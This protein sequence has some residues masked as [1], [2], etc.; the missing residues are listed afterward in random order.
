M[1]KLLL[2]VTGIAL[3]LLLLAVAGG[4]ALASGEE[5]VASDVVEV[6]VSND[7][8]TVS[9]ELDVVVNEAQDEITVEVIEPPAA[10]DA[11]DVVLSDDDPGDEHP[12]DKHD[13]E[14]HAEGG[15]GRYA[16]PAKFAAKVNVAAELLGMTPD[17]IIAQVQAGKRLY[18][19]AAEQGADADT[20]K[21]AVHA[22]VNEGG[23]CGCGFH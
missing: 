17:E 7:V 22:A 14:D 19:I 1:R 2:G 11:S 16:D 4:V 8:D 3:L 21:D 9:T 5:P 13:E 23:G 12:E 6:K 10:V 18:E 15:C 20:F